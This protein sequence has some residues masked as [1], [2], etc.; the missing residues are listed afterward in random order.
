VTHL[1]HY[2]GKEKGKLL[3]AAKSD[4][5]VIRRDALDSS[6]IR[7]LLTTETFIQRER[8]SAQGRSAKRITAD[9]LREFR[10]CLKINHKKTKHFNNYVEHR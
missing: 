5:T 2:D 4:A 1:K 6:Q 8:Q 7:T 10:S 3:K 9:R